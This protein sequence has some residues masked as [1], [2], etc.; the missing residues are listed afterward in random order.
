MFQNLPTELDVDDFKT[1]LAENSLE[2]KKAEICKINL[3]YDIDDLVS[4]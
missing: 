1:F 3:A 4:Y 2:G